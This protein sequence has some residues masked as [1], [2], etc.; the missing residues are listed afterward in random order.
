[1]HN[2]IKLI[3]YI[4]FAALISLPMWL[5]GLPA[6]VS[7]EYP[8]TQNYEETAYRTEYYNEPYSENITSTR[9]EVTGYE[10][11]PYHYWFSQDLLFQGVS[12]LWYYGYD[13]PESTGDAGVRLKIFINPQLQYEP[14]FMS[15]FDMTR[16][17]YLDYPDPVGPAGNSEKGQVAWSWIK[18][19]A[20]DTWLD[21][22]NALMTRAKFLGGRS[23]IWSKPGNV[24]I[25]DLDAGR[26]RNVA[27]LVSGPLNKWNASFT[28]YVA[29]YGTA[30]SKQSGERRMSRQLPY[31]VQKQRTV[32][33]VRQ[34]PFWE[35]WLP[36]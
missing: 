10:L 8:V 34:V 7:K 3:K 16:A 23:N 20:A 2:S 25:V 4:Q 13:L 5:I 33:E 29:A 11:L 9:A 30:E 36:R 6:C 18:G 12:N 24:Q 21:S 32:Y 26:A 1:M 22:A 31:Q 28:L 14:M 19:A 17:G 27:I 15:V 35:A